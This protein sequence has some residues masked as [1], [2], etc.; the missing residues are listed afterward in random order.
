[1][2]D[3]SGCSPNVSLIAQRIFGAFPTVVVLTLLWGLVGGV[4]LLLRY[5]AGGQEVEDLWQPAP[6]DQ[7]F[8][9]GLAA[10]LIASQP[11]DC[12]S[13]H[14]S[15]S[16]ILFHR[17]AAVFVA[18]RPRCRLDALPFHSGRCIG[19]ERRRKDFCLEGAAHSS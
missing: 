9:A 6:T 8:A 12:L 16:S 11:Q 10:P 18:V 19:A 15:R 3:L 1:M 5:D 13:I 2:L 7:V 4:Y 17:R 14:E